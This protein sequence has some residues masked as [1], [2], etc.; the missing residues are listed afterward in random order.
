MHLS[1]KSMVMAVAL[2]VAVAAGAQQPV[3]G[4]GAET[5]A[6]GD[7]P[8]ESGQVIK[9]FSLSYATYGTLN[10]AKSNA[11]LMVTAIGGNRSMSRVIFTVRSSNRSSRAGRRDTSRQRV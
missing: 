3:G 10:A 4:Q 7:L 6:E 8:L 9:D 2:G 1:S 5:Y 11:L